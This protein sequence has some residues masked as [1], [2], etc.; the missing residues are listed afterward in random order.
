M[1]LIDLSDHLH[2]D[3]T[4]K[5]I[6][7]SLMFLIPHTRTTQKKKYVP[8]IVLIFLLPNIRTS[9]KK[10]YVPKKLTDMWANL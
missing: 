2:K 6:C 10:K 4:G 9:Q 8:K 1:S 5:K 7:P 3:P